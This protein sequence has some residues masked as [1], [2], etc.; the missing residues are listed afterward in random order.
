M[1]LAKAS[2]R[3]LSNTEFVR[4]QSNNIVTVTMWTFKHQV[5]YENFHLKLA[6]WLTASF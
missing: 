5:P 4:F 2:N 6:E 1:L 3:A